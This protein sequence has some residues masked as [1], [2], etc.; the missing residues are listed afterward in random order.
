[1]LGGEGG[2]RRG[3]WREEKVREDAGEV[4]EGGGE[5]IGGL[6]R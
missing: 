3:D 6:R 5:V 1:M 2:W 4:R